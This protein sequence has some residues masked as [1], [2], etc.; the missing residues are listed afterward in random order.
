[1]SAFER[2]AD[3][4]RLAPRSSVSKVCLRALSGP[5]AV[6]E[7][8]SAHSHKRKSARHSG[9]PASATP[10]YCWKHSKKL[11]KLRHEMLEYI[12]DQDEFVI[13]V[14]PIIPL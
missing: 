4:E 2:K 8:M 14:R 1:M 7:L 13:F 10:P 6:A 9:R 3:V 12:V 11:K 5:R